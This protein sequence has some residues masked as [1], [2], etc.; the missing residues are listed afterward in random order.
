MTYEGESV[1]WPKMDITL[2]T[3]DVRTWGEGEHLFLDVFSTNFE[4]LV[5]SLY[6]RVKTCSR[7]VF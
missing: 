5:P 4:T 1:N 3:C 7:E 6:Q 2:K